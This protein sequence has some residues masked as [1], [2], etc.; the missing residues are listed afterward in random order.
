M[1]KS[2][3]TFLKSAAKDYVARSVNPPVVRAST[4]LFKTMQEL[5]KH[6]KD[7]AKVK[8]LLIGI[9]AAK[10]AKR[11]FNYKK[12]LRNWSRLIMCF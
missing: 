5:R 9:M 1:R 12:Y 10:E 4:I 7:I 11:Q 6:Q 2:I 8:M 3:K